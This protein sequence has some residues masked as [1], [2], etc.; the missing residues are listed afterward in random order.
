MITA[1]DTIE[2]ILKLLMTKPGTDAIYFRSIGPES[3]LIRAINNEIGLYHQ[4]L[5][6]MG[7][8]LERIGGTEND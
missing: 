8:E 3:A 4:S 1:T 6:D 2:N 5:D 7:D